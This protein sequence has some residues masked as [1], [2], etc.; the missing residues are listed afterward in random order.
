MLIGYD[1]GCFRRKMLFHSVTQ[2]VTVSDFC[3]MGGGRDTLSKNTT[4]KLSSSP[5]FRLAL[6]I[7]RTEWIQ[8]KGNPEREKLF[9]NIRERRVCLSQGGH[10]SVSARSRHID[11]RLLSA[12]CAESRLTSRCVWL[13][14]SH[15]YTKWPHYRQNLI[16]REFIWAS[17][18][19]GT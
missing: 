18:H 3:Q 14:C 17:H 16:S 1:L 9:L 8:H 5:K 11:G 7:I 19:I 2:E 4:W 13:P 15:H 10:P 12:R 6:P